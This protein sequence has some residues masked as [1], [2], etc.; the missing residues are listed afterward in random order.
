MLLRRPDS[1]WIQSIQKLTYRRTNWVASLIR[2]CVGWKRKI[3]HNSANPPCLTERSRF[4][5]TGHNV[6]SFTVLY[7]EQTLGASGC[8]VVIVNF[9]PRS[10]SLTSNSIVNLEYRLG[11][12]PCVFLLRLL[13][14]CWQFSVGINI[15]IVPTN[16]NTGAGLSSDH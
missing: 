3:G 2:E 10:T 11:F 12:L 16:L 6:E 5:W 14:R 9:P 1:S 4:L 13:R 8:V 15:H 7:C